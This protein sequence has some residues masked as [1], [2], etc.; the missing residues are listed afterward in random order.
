MEN[1]RYTAGFEDGRTAGKRE[2]VSTAFAFGLV[3]GML[4]AIWSLGRASR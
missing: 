2:G 4:I 1:D 3:T